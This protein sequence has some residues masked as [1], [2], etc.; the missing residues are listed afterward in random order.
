[1]KKE[2]QALK[3]SLLA[4]KVLILP[5]NGKVGEQKTA[6][7]IIVLTKDN[8]PKMEIGKVVA[9]GPGRLINDGTRVALDVSVGDKVY[10]KR[11]YDV[12]EI[13]LED[14]KYVLLSESNVYAIIK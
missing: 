13:T 2:K 8:E 12:E 5:E 10:F 1:M 14:V 7:G 6:T 9:V 3:I 4:D 11:G